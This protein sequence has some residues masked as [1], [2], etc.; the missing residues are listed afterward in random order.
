MLK[1]PKN[2]VDRER[3]RKRK[4]ERERRREKKNKKINQITIW[5]LLRIE[6]E[7]EKGREKK[8]ECKKGGNAEKSAKVWEKVYEREREKTNHTIVVKYSIQR[9]RRRPIRNTQTK[10]I[11]RHY[12]S[13]EMSPVRRRQRKTK[14]TNKYYSNINCANDRY[15]TN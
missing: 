14:L 1:L 11:I 15:G 8:G 9:R 2:G 4:N 10:Q 7:D 5:D 6:I 12:K 13:A 3:Q